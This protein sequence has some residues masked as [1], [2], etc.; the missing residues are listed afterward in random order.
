M[1]VDCLI[2]LFLL[3]WG[4]FLNVIAHRLLVN[5]S[6]ITGRSQCPACHT[7]IYWYDNIPLFSY[8][9]LNKQCRFCQAP[10][11]ILY[12]GMELLTALVF[13]LGFKIIDPLYWFSYALFFSALI[14]TLRT[15]LTDM[16][17]FA[18]TTLY[19]IP[20]AFVCSFL[21]ILPLT[22]LESFIGA[23]SAYLFLWFVA[24]IYTLITGRHGMGTGDFWLL[25]LIGS[26][27]GLEG[28]W[29]SLLIA[30]LL[31]TAFGIIGIIMKKL[32]HRTP[33]PFGPFLVLGALA[34]TFLTQFFDITLL[35]SATLS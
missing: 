26:F 19:I 1:I 21:R 6:W 30:S 35:Y 10:I 2:F 27:L 23:A 24:K 4:S 12:P 33:I 13:F 28:W 15:D 17:I 18:C 20:F 34:Y 7:I 31:G 32:S 14:I 5:K 9:I 29:F 22:I 8:F 25:S 16:L 3:C 11:S